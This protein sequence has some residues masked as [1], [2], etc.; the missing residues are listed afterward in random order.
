[1]D[2]SVTSSE[3][4]NY[5]D[6]PEKSEIV[7]QPPYHQTSNSE[8][9]LGVGSVVEVSIK[10]EP[11]YGVIRWIGVVLGDKQLREVAGIEMVRH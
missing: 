2:S 9:G 6:S 7:D 10:K 1:M 11:H 5:Y 4:T 3:V 8:S